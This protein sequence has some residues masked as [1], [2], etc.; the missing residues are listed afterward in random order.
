MKKILAYDILS[1][2]FIFHDHYIYQIL[3][4]K[5][6]YDNSCTG[7]IPLNEK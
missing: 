2:V 4:I 7:I 6:L 3:E 1:F 5:N